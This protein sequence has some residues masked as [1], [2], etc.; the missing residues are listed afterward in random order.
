MHQ[1]GG[2]RVGFR[3]LLIPLDMQRHLLLWL[4]LLHLLLLVRDEFHLPT[5]H[6]LHPPA[7]ARFH[8]FRRQRYPSHRWYS[9]CGYCWCLWASATSYYW[10]CWAS[11]AFRWWGCWRC[12]AKGIW[13]R[14]YRVITTFFVSRPYCQTYLGHRGSISWIH[15]F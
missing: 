10:C 1:C 3:R 11:V 7:G 4:M 9:Y 14:T 5:H 8:I 13:R 12:W 6:P 2:R 15:S